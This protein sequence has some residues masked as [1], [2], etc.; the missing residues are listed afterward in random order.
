MSMGFF[1]ST[2]RLIKVII[3]IIKFLMQVRHKSK[4]KIKN[5]C[6]LCAKIQEIQSF[7]AQ[8]EIASKISSLKQFV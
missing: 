2:L 8:M 5:K 6:I 1:S 7:K 4:S 3:I